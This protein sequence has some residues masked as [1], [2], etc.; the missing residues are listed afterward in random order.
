[1]YLYCVYKIIH[2]T[3]LILEATAFRIKYS[4][5]DKETRRTFFTPPLQEVQLNNHSRTQFFSFD[6]KQHLIKTNIERYN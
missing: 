6:A 1:M 3:E 5:Y 4:C 2:Y